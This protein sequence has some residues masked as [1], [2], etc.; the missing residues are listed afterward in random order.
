MT[1]LQLSYYVE[2]CRLQ[3]FTR[4]AQNM[5]VTQPTVTNAVRDLENEFG[6]RLL[7][8]TNKTLAL[9]P[10]GQELFEMAVQLLNFSDQIHMVMSDR[11]KESDRLLLGSPIMTSAACFPEFFRMLHRDYPEV[12]IQPTHD[13]TV[14]LLE[15]L[16]A[17]KINMAL[18]PYEPDSHKYEFLLWKK[19]RFLF[20]VSEHHPLAAKSSVSFKDICREPLL[21]YFRD[22]YLRNFN[23]MEKYRENGV[24]MKIV[25]RC[26]QINILH[27]L[28]REGE[29]C[30][31]LIE[32]SFLSGHGIVGIPL[33]EE[34]PVN[35]YLV[36]TQT[37]S[38]LSV[39]QK[40]LKSVRS[41]LSQ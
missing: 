34:L 40:V 19:T 36:W 15:L 12:E 32:N 9:T 38:R 25:Y 1:L 33:K 18:I 8:R 41:Y 5:N 10:A 14:N 22:I 39:V 24:E 6:V 4:A 31:F 21:S 28:I 3:N 13:I 26:G 27:D 30:G 11:A 35:L 29:G 17:G 16:D 20:C 37:S 2:V 7:E 23:L